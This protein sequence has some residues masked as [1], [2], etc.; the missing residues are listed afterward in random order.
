MYDEAHR[1]P[2]AYGVWDCRG[3]SFDRGQRSWFVRSML[4]RATLSLWCVSEELQSSIEICCIGSLLTFVRAG[5]NGHAMLCRTW[6]LLV[7]R[8]SLQRLPG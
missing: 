6:C 4:A 7:R 5:D 1:T 2:W 3:R 8:P